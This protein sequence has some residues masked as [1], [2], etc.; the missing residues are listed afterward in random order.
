MCQY[1][2][3][4]RGSAPDPAGGADDASPD[5]LV[6]WRGVPLP[7]PF[8]PWHFRRPDLFSMPTAPRFLSPTNKKSSRYTYVVREEGA[9]MI[10]LQGGDIWSYST[11]RPLSFCHNFVSY[12]RFLN[13][14]ILLLHGFVVSS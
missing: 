7:I 5:P 3:S 6:G 13:S 14:F 1:P 11:G 4:A 10:F 9:R 12:D 8:L 2:F